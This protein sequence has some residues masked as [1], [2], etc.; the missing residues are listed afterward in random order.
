MTFLNPLDALNPN[1]PFSF[2]AEFWIPDLW[3][4]PPQ[5]E[6]LVDAPPPP[7]NPTETVGRIDPQ[8]PRRK[9]AHPMHCLGSVKSL[10]N[11]V[12]TRDRGRKSPAH[13]PLDSPEPLRTGC[14]WWAWVQV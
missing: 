3:P 7:P 4:D 5:K 14:W 13:Q 10:R 8:P 6:M 1:I 9:P 11:G 12:R 2:F